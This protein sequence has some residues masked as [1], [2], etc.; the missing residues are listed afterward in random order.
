MCSI[1][2]Y[3][4]NVVEVVAKV[5]GV[6]E[7]QINGKCR[8]REIVDARWLVIQL[9]RKAGYYPRQIARQK[10]TSV[11]SIHKALALFEFRVKYSPDPMLRTYCEQCKNLLG[12]N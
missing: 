10:G 5:T 8:L 1:R 12:I 7:E 4:Q 6:T 2:D 11:R 3:Y 9:M